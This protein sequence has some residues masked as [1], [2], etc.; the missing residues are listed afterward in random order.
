M[1]EDNIT[2]KPNGSDYHIRKFFT[3]WIET[4]E[5]SINERLKSIQDFIN[6][7]DRRYEERF[8]AQESS[9]ASALIA[10]EKQHV[11]AT[12][13]SEKAIEKALQAQAQ[14]NQSHNDLIRKM[15]GQYKEMIPRSEHEGD[16]KNLSDKHDG[17]KN[18]V[19]GLRESRSESGG[20][21]IKGASDKSLVQWI[22]LAI[23]TIVN[24]A[25]NLFLK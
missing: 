17:L 23:F 24:I 1:D 7:R 12:L 10:I 15:D 16:I 8:R 21:E 13:A 18:D 3:L 4:L 9:V 2:Q 25:I 11:Q 6:E 5:K 14:Y 20:K 22:I 19:Q